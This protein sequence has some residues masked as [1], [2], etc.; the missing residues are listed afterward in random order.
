MRRA[1]F[2][3]VALSSVL[4]IAPV[5]AAETTTSAV[6][7]VQVSGRTSLKVSTDNLRFDVAISSTPATSTV[8]FSA[9]ARTQ[10]GAEVVLSVE[11]LCRVLEPG[12]AAGEESPVSFTGEGDGALDGLLG[13]ADRAVAG[14]WIGSGLRRGR[15]VFMMR[16]GA[17]GTY[18]VPVRF[19][20]S[21]P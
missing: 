11:R 19:F 21:A 14:R 2:F 6:V 4:A 20:L 9:G 3:A 1:L 15:L 10:A 12:G 7:S 5:F 18:I 16:A 8:D 17:A 13:P